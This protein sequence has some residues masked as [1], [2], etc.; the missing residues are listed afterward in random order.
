[1]EVSLKFYISLF[2][3][4]VFFVIIVFLYNNK[5]EVLITE[6]VYQESSISQNVGGFEEEIPAFE[7][8]EGLIF[9]V[10]QEDFLAFSSPFGHRVSPFLRKEVRHNGVDIITVWRAQVVSVSDG[11]VLEH[12]PAPGTRHPS[13]GTFRGHPIYGGMILIEHADGFK[14]LYAHLD[15]TN[16]HTGQFVRAGSLIGRV[17]N[18]GMATGRHLH[19]EMVVNDFHVNPLLYFNTFF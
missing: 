17:G 14:T 16:V 5:E 7:F 9:P 2:L 10:K 12:W 6:V 4:I 15:S 13:G 8:K 19:F 18:T 11:V 3:N 1:M